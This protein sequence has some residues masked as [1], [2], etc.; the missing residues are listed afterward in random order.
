VAIRERAAPKFKADPSWIQ[1]RRCGRIP[2]A[3]RSEV[4]RFLLP[5]GALEKGPNGN[6]RPMECVARLA[7][8]TLARRN[9]DASVPTTVRAKGNSGTL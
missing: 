8:A 4:L 7:A 2:I 9:G 3:N 1:R 6:V 5:L